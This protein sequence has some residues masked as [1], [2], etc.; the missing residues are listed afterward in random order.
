MDRFVE[1]FG[2][3]EDPRAANAR[4]DLVEMLFIALLASLCGARSCEEM[5]EFGRAKQKLLRRFLTLA[6]GVA[7]HDTFSRLFRLID[8]KALELAFS[9]FM[10]RFARHVC[11]VVALDGKA[12]RGAYEK[13]FAHMPAMMVGAFAAETRLSLAGIAAEGGDERAAAL[14]LIDLIDLHGCVVTADAL[15]CHADMAERVGARGGDYALRLK[16]N[17]PGLLKGAKAAL[18]GAGVKTAR[19]EGKRGGLAEART[20]SVAPA[21]ALA[22]ASGFPHLQA[23]A[24]II[25]ERKGKESEERF[26]LL[27]R[28]FTPERLM[29]IA[30]QH[31][32][33]ENNLHWTLDTVFFEDAARSRKDNA[34]QNLATMRRLALNIARMH[35]DKKTPMRRKLMRAA[36]NEDFFFEL[37]RHMR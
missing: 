23:V 25:H 30:R 33:I 24:R 17:Q 14:Q 36:W 12:L 6:H 29:T 27:S 2:E 31:W 35:P 3:I 5:S 8:P 1:C 21:G 32:S 9:G 10:E 16:A 7:S 15:H 18:D 28:R 4:H 11:G 26:Y 13:G 19:L 20:A 22:A 34:P 37:I